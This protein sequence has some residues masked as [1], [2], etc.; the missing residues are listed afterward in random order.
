VNGGEPQVTHRCA[1]LGS[2]VAHSLSPV[3]HRAAYEALGLRGWRYVRHECDE[4]GLP[5]F[6]AGLDPTWAGLSLTMPLKRAAIP[7]LDEVSPLALAVEAVNTV[8][9]APGHRR[10]ENTDVP[11]LQSVLADTGRPVPAEAVVLGGGATAASALAALAGHGVRQITVYAR[12]PARARG[13]AETASRFGLAVEVAPWPGPDGSDA[14][15]DLARVYE[16]PLVVSTVPSGAADALADLLARRAPAVRGL[17]VDVVYAPW[18]TPLATA[19]G[20]LGGPV[21]GGLEMLVHQAALQVELF[22]GVRPPIP[23]L[24]RAGE[25]A[26]AAGTA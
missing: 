20:R 7:L 17:L 19:W 23:P 24:R 13:A 6:L 2:P 14:P 9:C 10:G 4:T 22:A 5:A 25:A 15:V 1:V 26:L 12:T 11:G 8:V 3:L 18:P 21:V 16:A